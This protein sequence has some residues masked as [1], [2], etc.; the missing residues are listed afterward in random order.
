MEMER[1]FELINRMEK[2]NLTKLELEMGD[3]SLKLAKEGNGS[4]VIPQSE[5]HTSS[6]AIVGK[7]ILSPI[8]GTFYASSSPEKEPFVQV[9]QTIHEGEV[10]CLI[11]AMKLFNEVQ[12]DFNGTVKQILVKDG[13]LLEFGQPIMVI[14]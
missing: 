6:T 9:G 13:D 12:S 1:I 5:P 3:C 10:V 2:S 7:T 4:L 8:V 14:E 11:E